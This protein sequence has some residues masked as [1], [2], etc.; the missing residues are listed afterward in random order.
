MQKITIK[1]GHNINISGLAS[2]EFSSAPTQKFVSL[3]PQDFNYIKPKL[4]VKEGDHVSLG[5]ALF[6]DKINPDVKWP[7]IAAGTISKIVYG[8]RRAVLDI[9]I[10]VDDNKEKTSQII[11]ERNLSTKEDVKNFIQNNNLWPFFTQRPFNKVVDPKDSPKC[12]IVSLA[13][14]SPLANDLSFSLSD[15]KDNIVSAL[16]NIKKLTDGNL[17]VAVRGDNFSFLS[18]YDFINLVQVEGPHPS[19]NVGVILNK[20]N[21]LN[22]NEVVWT[23]QG[24]HLP[25][26]GKLF[27]QGIYDFSLN[28][29]IGGP[30]VKPSY[31]K[32][33]IGARFDLYKDS[34]LKDNVRIIS[35]NVLTG[36]KVN[37]DG[38]LGFYHTFFSVI[39]ESFDRPFVGWLHPGGKSKYSVFN[40]YFGSNKKSY[41]FTTLQNGSNRAFVP[42]DAWEKVF[43][44]DIYIN[45]LARSI[46]ANDIDE[47]EQLGIYECDE[48]D[49][50]LCSFVCPSKSDV[51]AIIRKGLDTIYF[52]K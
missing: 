26:L 28:I 17:Y 35:G 33:R 50:A 42:V 38:F 2:R 14:S 25:I 3:S 40:A 24:S 30:S 27:T 10:E 23:V 37:L 9:I 4:L 18:D 32:S 45:A 6:F 13:D 36:K 52:D 8:E 29:S 15:K 47:M 34:L 48:E 7:S 22:Q 12:I 11:N 31:F 51:G 1:K 41:D 43:P 16:S 21:P 39:E 44:M 20:V 19:G 5:D 46:E 49:V